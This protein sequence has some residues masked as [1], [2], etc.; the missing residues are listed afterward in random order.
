MRI[1]NESLLRMVDNYQT[2]HSMR[3]LKKYYVIIVY[4]YLATCLHNNMHNTCMNLA[5]YYALC[6]SSAYVYVYMYESRSDYYA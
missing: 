3:Y 1:N 4:Y 6:A 5:M 2:A